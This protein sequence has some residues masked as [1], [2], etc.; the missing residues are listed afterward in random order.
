MKKKTITKEHPLTAFRKANEARNAMV[1]KSLPKAKVGT[2]TG[3]VKPTYSR[4]FQVGTDKDYSGKDQ[5]SNAY[6][7][8]YKTTSDGKIVSRSSASQRANTIGGDNVTSYPENT[9]VIDTT[10]YSKGKKSFPAKK[11]TYNNAEINYDN[12]GQPG[13][14]PG[15]STYSEWD[16]PRKDVKKTIA[17]MKS[18]SGAN[19]SKGTNVNYNSA[20]TKTVI[21]TGADGKKYVKVTDKDGKTFNKVINK[22]TGGMITK[23]QSRGEVNESSKP[24]KK[25]VKPTTVARP[26][27]VKV[28][29]VIQPIKYA[30]P[31]VAIPVRTSK[32]V[33]TSNSYV[34]P[35]VVT[36]NPMAG[37]K[38]NKPRPVGKYENAVEN[39]YAVK[40]PSP[41]TSNKINADKI[42]PSRLESD[43]IK[44]IKSKAV[45]STK[46]VNKPKLKP[47]L[48][49]VDKIKLG[50]LFPTRAIM[51]MYKKKGGAVKTKK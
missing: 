7:K 28:N 25:Y 24:V 1:K 22:K 27:E 32:P 5:Y 41:A 9:T 51:E 40:K 33:R 44:T 14:R 13:A 4:K 39:S 20:G 12:I 47:T 11:S 48:S 17:Q 23:Y 26:T 31:T 36:D 35:P 10:G 30:K 15:R 46:P 34:K 42:K 2:T 19:K 29:G 6:E 8:I 50:L 3:D 45:A 21:H 49:T 43:K 16:V 18:N 37:F 38:V